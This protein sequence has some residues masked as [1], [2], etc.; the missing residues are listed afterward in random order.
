MVASILIR[1]SLTFQLAY[2]KDHSYAFPTPGYEYAEHG[3]HW[4]KP[5]RLLPLGSAKL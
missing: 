2:A 1:C 3:K 4:V 5:M